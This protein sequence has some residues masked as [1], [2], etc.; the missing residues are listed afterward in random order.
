MEQIYYDVDQEDIHAESYALVNGDGD[1]GECFVV[2]VFTQ[3][4]EY[5]VLKALEFP[6]ELSSE[7]PWMLGAVDFINK[8]ECKKIDMSSNAY[9]NLDWDMLQDPVFL[10]FDEFERTVLNDLND[11]GQKDLYKSLGM[12]P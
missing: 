12:K 4:Q 9:R 6:V 10:T 3:E 1:E 5:I 2:E 7:Y 8:E 11:M